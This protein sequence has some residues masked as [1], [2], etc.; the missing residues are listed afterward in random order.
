MQILGAEYKEAMGQPC[1]VCGDV[2]SDHSA[3]IPTWSDEHD[4]I[5][6]WDCSNKRKDV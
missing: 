2:M 3:F 5:V 4:N 6:C 1:P